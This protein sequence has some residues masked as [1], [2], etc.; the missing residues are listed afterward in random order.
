MDK[1]LTGKRPEFLIGFRNKNYPG[2][3]FDFEL[4]A[5]HN[6]I[7]RQFAQFTGIELLW[8]LRFRRSL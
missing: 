1:M 3:T 4:A 7:A 8:S 6:D 2:L 5:F